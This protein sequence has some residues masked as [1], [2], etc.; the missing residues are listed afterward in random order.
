MANDSK[1]QSCVVIGAGLCG[2][3]TAERLVDAGWSVTVLEKLN[4]VAGLARSF[5]DDGFIFD[6]GPHYFFLNVRPDVSDYAR[7]N[8]KGPFQELDFRISTHFKGREI[9]WPPSPTSLF[10]L[11]LRSGIHYFRKM[12]RHEHPRS[13]DYRGFTTELYGPAMYDAFFGP[14]IQKK[15]PSVRG[16]E[17]HRDWWILAKRTI[18]N[19]LDVG[20]D[21]LLGKLGS[22][23]KPP[24]GPPPLKKR[25]MKGLDMAYRMALNMTSRN[26]PQVLYP[27]GG[28]GMIGE[29]IRETFEKKGGNLVL[30]CGGVKLIRDGGG[31][32][33]RVEWAGGA[34]DRPD[35]VVWTGS[36]HELADQLG[37]ERAKVDYL[38]IALVYVTTKKPLRGARYFYTYYSEPE[39]IFNR[40]YFPTRACAELAPPGCDAVCAEVSPEGGLDTIDRPALEKKV[41]DG[42]VKL[43]HLDREDVLSVKVRVA[44]DSYPVYPLDYLARLKILWDQ[45][46]TVDNLSAV[47]RTGQFYYNN[48][49]L[50]I[51]LGI[52]LSRRLLGQPSY[53]EEQAAKLRAKTGAEPLTVGNGAAPALD[54]DH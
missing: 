14:Y 22:P 15:L 6:V 48:M 24:A 23:G 44:R 43:G 4:G 18:D 37:F 36:I 54:R 1:R 41:I 33:T 27:N 5:N 25:L 35:H 19:D 8:V 34:V 46:K 39:L 47:G 42:L 2:L 45:L 51:C 53:Y 40:L 28:I 31:K 30:N 38:S 16:P 29:G 26:L 17:L 21:R 11:P 52:D 32:I 49:A 12:M 7:A 3:S 13:T 9:A 20:K 10:K 50:T